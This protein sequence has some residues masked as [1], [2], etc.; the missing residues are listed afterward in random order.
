LTS[1][2]EQSKATQELEDSGLPLLARAATIEAGNKDSEDSSSEA[3]EKVHAE[4]DAESNGTDLSTSPEEIVNTAI[5]T[6][7]EEV[8]EP[9]TSTAVTLAVT[10]KMREANAMKKIQTLENRIGNLGTIKKYGY[11]ERLW[12]VNIISDY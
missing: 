1:G 11:F 3:E 5:D 7:I 9:S 6:A 10:T 2:V 8:G 12:K 4:S